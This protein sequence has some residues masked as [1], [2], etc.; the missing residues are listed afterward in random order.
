MSSV[1]EARQQLR[2]TIATARKLGYYNLECEARLV[3]SELEMKGNPAGGRMQLASLATDARSH[4]L[5]LLARHAEQAASA[6]V[7]ASNKPA[8]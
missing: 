1:S 6:N 3:L 4:G 7:L 5:E 8:P 2:S